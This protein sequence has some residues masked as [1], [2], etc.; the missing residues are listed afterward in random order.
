MLNT[1]SRMGLVTETKQGV[2][3]L[4]RYVEHLV[5]DHLRERGLLL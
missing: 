3:E 1:L 5:T 2:I 4:N